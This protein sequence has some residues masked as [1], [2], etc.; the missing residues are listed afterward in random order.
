[1][2]F[3]RQQKTPATPFLSRCALD[4]PTA[5][6]RGPAVASNFAHSTFPTTA[7]SSL[8]WVDPVQHHGLLRGHP[9]TS[10]MDVMM[11]GEEIRDKAGPSKDSS[12]PSPS[13]VARYP[14]SWYAP[15]VT[16]ESATRPSNLSPSPNPPSD[17]N[18]HFSFS[19]MA[20]S[21][22][23]DGTRDVA[24]RPTAQT[25][26]SP[27]LACFIPQPLSSYSDP[28]NSGLFA[29]QHPGDS[30]SAYLADHRHTVPLPDVLTPEH[31][32]EI[33]RETVLTVCTSPCAQD[34]RGPSS[35]MVSGASSLRVA[36]RP[37]RSS[38]A[39]IRCKDG[40]YPC[41]IR[42]KVCWGV[43]SLP[44]CWILLSS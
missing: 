32:H 30:V 7:P 26:G 22:F 27:P 41:R 43:R 12:T 35:H 15:H 39:Q 25:M 33:F 6:M 9:S 14:L 4:P 23:D 18:V 20:L 11:P 37:L 3:E 16:F 1:M 40:C 31:D 38:S 19:S 42:S 13:L 21:P 28:S 2:D 24:V 29:L 5:L 34:T 10:V 36:T 44:V 17:G 8:P